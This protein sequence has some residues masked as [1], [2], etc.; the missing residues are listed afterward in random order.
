MKNIGYT[1]LLLV[2]LM[3][4]SC[5]KESEN[6]QPSPSCIIN[7]FDLKEFE[8][9]SNRLVKIYENKT[10]LKGF[11]TTFDYD[12][13][14]RP[15]KMTKYE[16]NALYS[17][18]SYT[19][20]NDTTVTFTSYQTDSEGKERISIKDGLMIYNMSGVLKKIIY[21]NENYRRYEYNSMGNV[22]KV[23]FKAGVGS[24]ESLAVEF[25]GYDN[26]KNFIFLNRAI[27][28]YYYFDNYG[29]YL[30]KNNY[31]QAKYYDA[32]GKLLLQRDKKYE[33]NSQAYVTKITTSSNNMSYD[34]VL[35]YTC[36]P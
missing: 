16:N 24:T 31:L 28:Y 7:S 3:Q 29:W 9:S 4:L 22:E 27:S 36:T 26:M 23:F 5:K 2:S 33:Y 12:M 21:A 18:T 10:S 34:E 8:Y 20:T 1:I 19:Y 30:S 15:V 25:K 32:D 17:Y 35:T 6:L 11:F 14:G 13:A